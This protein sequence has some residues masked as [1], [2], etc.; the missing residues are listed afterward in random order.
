MITSDWFVTGSRPN[1]RPDEATRV[2]WHM[3]QSSAG[4]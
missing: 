1:Q 4:L 3:D 2:S